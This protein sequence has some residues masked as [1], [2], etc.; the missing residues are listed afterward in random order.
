MSAF[1]IFYELIAPRKT[2]LFFLYG[3]PFQDLVDPACPHFDILLLQG[4]FTSFTTK[5]FPILSPLIQTLQVLFS[6]TFLAFFLLL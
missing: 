5:I 6:P 2:P 3:V 4:T 1:E